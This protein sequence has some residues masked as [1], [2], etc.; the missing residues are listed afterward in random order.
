MSDTISP[1]T[2]DEC[3]KRDNY[4]CINPRC[5]FRDKVKKL[6]NGKEIWENK[7]WST[8][9]QAWVQTK[10]H[11]HHCFFRSR[12]HGI[13]KHGAWNLVCLCEGCHDLL[14]NPHPAMKSWSKDLEE[15]CIDL[16]ISRREE[17]GMLPIDYSADAKRFDKPKYMRREQRTEYQKKQREKY[18]SDYQKRKERFMKDN[19]GL[20]PMQVAYRRKKQL[21]SG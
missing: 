21:N 5:P 20:T 15:M 10:I 6:S 9:Y 19:G 7:R 14:H 4:L 11:L 2:R 8:T 3:Y 16:A 18:K 12:Y 17:A 13:D 1:Q